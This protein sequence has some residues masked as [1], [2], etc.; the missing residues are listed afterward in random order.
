MEQ[1][2][3]NGKPFRRTAMA[4]WLVLTTRGITNRRFN[5]HLSFEGDIFISAAI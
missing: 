2:F 5:L 3:S 4:L 1:W